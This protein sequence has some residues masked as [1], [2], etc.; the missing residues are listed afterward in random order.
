M[1]AKLG[2]E[3]GQ[4]LLDGVKTLTLLPLQAHTG[5]L[6]LKLRQKLP[7][8][9]HHVL[10]T[11]EVKARKQSGLQQRIGVCWRWCRTHDVAS[12]FYFTN[13]LSVPSGATVSAQG[14]QALPRGR[15]GKRPPYTCG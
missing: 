6:G 2:A 9:Q 14:R 7:H 5:Q 11:D 15:G 3:P 4:F 13:A 12:F 8:C 1:I 10:R